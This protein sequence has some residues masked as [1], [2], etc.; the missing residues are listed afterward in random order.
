M[1]EPQNL[2]AKPAEGIPDY[3]K[4]LAAWE[5]MKKRAEKVSGLPR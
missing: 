2:P 3:E 5:K 1:I 4:Q